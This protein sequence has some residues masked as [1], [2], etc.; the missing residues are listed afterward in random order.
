MVMTPLGARREK[1][2]PLAPTRQSSRRRTRN[3]TKSKIAA[4]CSDIREAELRAIWART[5]ASAGGRGKLRNRTGSRYKAIPLQSGLRVEEFATRKGDEAIPTSNL[6]GTAMKKQ[7]VAVTGADAGAAE[8]SGA[9]G[10]DHSWFQLRRLADSRRSCDRRAERSLR[11]ASK[12]QADTPATSP[13]TPVGDRSTRNVTAV[14]IVPV[15]DALVVQQK[16]R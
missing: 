14:D 11:D 2:A 12:R 3:G 13:G 9:S 4:C 1:T 10:A 5:I 15:H 6:Q 8:R 16:N 7:C